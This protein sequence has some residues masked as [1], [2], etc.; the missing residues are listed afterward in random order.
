MVS[1]RRLQ[2]FMMYDELKPGEKNDAK[3]NMKN[4]A[5]ND[6]K[7]DAKNDVKVEMKEDKNAQDTKE[8]SAEHK[9][10]DQIAHDERDRG[11][12]QYIISLKNATTKWL[13]HEKEDTLQNI[14]INVRPGELIAIVGQVGSGKS[15]LMNVILKELRLQQGTIQVHSQP[16]RHM[17]NINLKRLKYNKKT[18]YLLNWILRNLR[19]A[20]VILVDSFKRID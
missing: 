2:Q 19:M 15:S 14:N 1:I 7:K 10:S 4:D 13:N 11:E 3:N 8:S 12:Q 17:I 5:K 16:S 18:A 20:I 9:K 6:T